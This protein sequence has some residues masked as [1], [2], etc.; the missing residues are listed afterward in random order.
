[1]DLVH[2][3]SAW[4]LDQL[5]ISMEI[6]LLNEKGNDS[7]FEILHSACQF[8]FHFFLMELKCVMDN[9]MDKNCIIC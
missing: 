4:S 7:G 5:K 9:L 6:V 8:Y 2:I 3:Y 1:M